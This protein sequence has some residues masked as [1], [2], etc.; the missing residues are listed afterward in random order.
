MS[1][2]AVETRS[3]SRTDRVVAAI[4]QMILD[5]ELAAGDR[6]PIEAALAEKLE[7]SRGSLREGVRALAVLG[8]VEAR[9][10]DGTFVT[11]LA[12]NVLLGP[13]GLLVELQGAG[14]SLHVHSVRRLLEAEAAAQAAR[15]PA[16]EFSARAR[17]AIDQAEELFAEADAHSTDHERFIDADISFH[18]VIADWS[19][20]PVLAA[21]VEAFAGR[22]ARHRLRH[23]QLEPG[24]DLRAHR[25]H[26]A[27][28]AAITD[29]DG[30]RARV[31]MSAHLLEIEDFLR[32]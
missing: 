19:G 29:G 1:D 15:N 18:R 14:H 26:E 12:P 10:G 5:G 9:Q 20:N 32:E 31:L 25:A 11:S 30:D 7:V 6:L 21:M 2:P 22:T 4:T 16:S 24:A 28:L 13:L 27:I 23:G 8:I 17:A 3:A